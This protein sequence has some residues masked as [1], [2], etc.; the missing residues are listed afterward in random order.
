MCGSL[1]MA[2]SLPMTKDRWSFI[3]FFQ[4]CLHVGSGTIMKQPLIVDAG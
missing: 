2:D 4:N 3:L 1:R